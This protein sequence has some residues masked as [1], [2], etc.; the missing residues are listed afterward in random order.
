MIYVIIHNIT[1][2]SHNN[3]VIIKYTAFLLYNNIF[4]TFN[5]IV[6]LVDNYIKNK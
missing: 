4:I 5:V 1:N 6:N 2:I 3:I